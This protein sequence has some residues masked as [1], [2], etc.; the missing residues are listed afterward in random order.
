MFDITNHY[1]G[2]I[3]KHFDQTLIPSGIRMLF[4]NGNVISIQFGYGNYC[5]NRDESKPECKTAEIA[6]WNKNGD[7]FEFDGGD[8]VKGWC[9]TD[10][11]AKWINFAANNEIT[12]KNI[13]NDDE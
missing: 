11:V 5:D 13:E 4:G 7:W 10:E 2:Y 8:T 1:K 6:I 12:R 3:G 9:D